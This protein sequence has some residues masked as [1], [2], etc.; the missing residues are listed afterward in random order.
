[1]YILK[2]PIG[3]IQCNTK[4]ERGSDYIKAQGM[5]AD[6]GTRTDDFSFTGISDFSRYGLVDE[7]GNPVTF[8]VPDTHTVTE[9]AI[10]AIVTAMADAGQVSEPL[11]HTIMARAIE[12]VN[13]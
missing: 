4:P 8:N 12:I 13:E 7:N 6:S 5:I 3:D 9:E 11:A 2:T 10:R 1:M